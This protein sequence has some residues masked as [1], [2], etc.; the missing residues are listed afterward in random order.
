MHGV[1]HQLLA[2]GFPAKQDHLVVAVGIEWDQGETGRHDFRIDLTDPT[3]SPAITING[4]TDVAERVAGEAPPQTRL[5]MPLD[6]VVFPA[7][8]SYAFELVVSEGE[9]IPLCPLHLIE[10]PD[11]R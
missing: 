6:G 5:I 10:N 9:R 3:G 7:P 8:G 1:F 4:H 11:A 2:P